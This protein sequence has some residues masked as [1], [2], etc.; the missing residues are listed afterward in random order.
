MNP[1]GEEPEGREWW[2]KLLAET[3]R[4]TNVYLLRAVISRPRKTKKS[5]SAE[6]HVIPKTPS[7]ERF[8]GVLLYEELPEGNETGNTE[9]WSIA[10]RCTSSPMAKLSINQGLEK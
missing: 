7:P 3:V 1:C 9:I 8:P 2:S 6:I 5:C 4:S 10:P